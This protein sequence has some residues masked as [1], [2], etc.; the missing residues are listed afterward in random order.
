MDKVLPLVVGR[1]V[2]IV[3]SRVVP[4]VVSRWW[5]GRGSGRGPVVAPVG[6][7]V[8]VTWMP[9]WWKWPDP[10]HSVA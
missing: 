6:G 7:P 3:V 4:G 9:G 5:T 8:A 10:C 2:A 1:V